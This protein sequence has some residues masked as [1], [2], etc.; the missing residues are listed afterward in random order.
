[1]SVSFLE[2][3]RKN[4]LSFVNLKTFGLTTNSIDLV[5]KSKQLVLN[6]EQ[7]DKYSN[8]YTL[9][10]TMHSFKLPN[11]TSYPIQINPEIIPIQ[12]NMIKEQIKQKRK[13]IFNKCSRNF[14]DIIDNNHLQ[15]EADC[16]NDK[17]INE[18]TLMKYIDIFNNKN[19]IIHKYIEYKEKYF[20]NADIN[21]TFLNG[22]IECEGSLTDE[23]TKENKFTIDNN[24]IGIKLKYQ[25][26][27]IVFVDCNTN[28]KV[29]SIKLPFWLT[30]FI[31]G[32]NYDIF[33]VFLSHVIEYNNN[34]KTFN[35]NETKF[36]SLFNLIVQKECFDREGSLLSLLN[37]KQKIQNEFDW[38]VLNQTKLKY[39]MKIVLPQMSFIIVLYEEKTKIKFIKQSDY[40]HIT[41]FIKN[42]FKDWD[43][44]LLN[45]FCVYQKFRYILNKSLSFDNKY[46]HQN[47]KINLSL[48]INNNN[49]INSFEFYLTKANNTNRFY[50]LKAPKVK[51]IYN[52]KNV[53]IFD[54]S[55]KEIIQINKLHKYFSAE[56][57]LRK[58]ICISSY[59]DPLF[60]VHVVT[61]VDLNL[62]NTIFALKPAFLDLIPNRRKISFSTIK[63]DSYTLII[64]Q[65][66]IEWIDLN[67][68]NK[69]ETK[70]MIY[71]I[72]DKKSI[73][74]FG[75]IDINQWGEF[76]YD[77]YDDIEHC[78]VENNDSFVLFEEEKTECEMN[79][80]S[81]KK[82][83]SSKLK[84]KK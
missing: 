68:S 38:I 63:T 39:K 67:I 62:S 32:I 59:Y 37:K 27:K 71:K 24:R 72:N 58:C 56:E 48:R 81:L 20:I 69:I 11:I 30:T 5:K 13:R 42:N 8:Y 18:I 73:Y 75:C 25:N 10:T 3:Y 9:M 29:S 41:Y 14:T 84:L 34:S 55:L 6:T 82:K 26:V 45:A 78:S 70:N 33:K 28:K 77:F 53:K 12:N 2:S 21:K 1:M 16:I 83:K 31:Y 36:S 46:N 22:I 51:F 76:I 44:Y 47:I 49:S 52:N 43:F 74:L 54:L 65:S 23:S 19:S 4:L 80:A 60:N 35:I 57:I 50:K 15:T 7:Y 17:E 40:N 66:T 79:V 61:S 64:S